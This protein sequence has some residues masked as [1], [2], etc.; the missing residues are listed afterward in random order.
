MQ[1]DSIQAGSLAMTPDRKLGD[2]TRLSPRSRS[3]SSCHHRLALREVIDPKKIVEERLLSV[4]AAPV[5]RAVI[6]DGNVP[7]VDLVVA[8]VNSILSF[9]IAV[10][11]RLDGSSSAKSDTVDISTPVSS[12]PT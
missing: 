2:F 4:S 10:I 5:L 11:D 9:P 3:S 7:T 12:L 8:F 6:L 1:A